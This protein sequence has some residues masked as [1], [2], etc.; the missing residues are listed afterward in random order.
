MSHTEGE[1]EKG[2]EL[3][4]FEVGKEYRKDGDNE[5]IL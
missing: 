1:E 4:Y 3:A 5:K 2:K